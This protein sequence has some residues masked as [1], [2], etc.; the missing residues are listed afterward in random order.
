MV[1][2]ELY[3]GQEPRPC[4]ALIVT[5]G[6]KKIKRWSSRAD[7]SLD[8]PLGEE[9]QQDDRDGG[10]MAG[11][12]SAGHIPRIPFVGSQTVADHFL[13][14]RRERQVPRIKKF[15]DGALTTPQGFDLIIIDDPLTFGGSIGP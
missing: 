10:G 6:T 7:K 14:W 12:R 15:S 3:G 2:P 9:G 13:I 8:R 1:S 11:E 5:A 4:Q